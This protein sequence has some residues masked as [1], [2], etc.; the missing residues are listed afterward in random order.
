MLPI[1]NGHIGCKSPGDFSPTDS[2]AGGPPCARRSDRPQY[3]MASVG[4][5]REPLCVMSQ[6]LLVGIVDT[7]RRL[8]FLSGSQWL[9]ATSRFSTSPSLPASPSSFPPRK[10]STL[11]CPL[12]SQHP[13][14]GCTVP[15]PT[16]CLPF[17]HFCSRGP[18]VCANPLSPECI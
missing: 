2:A 16:S 13:E 5:R 17:P 12:C 1:K 14:H 8:S 3:L 11:C 6:A 10:S 9:H 4:E 18:T 15:R 7:T